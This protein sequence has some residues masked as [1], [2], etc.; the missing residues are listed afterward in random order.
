MILSFGWIVVQ[1]S[2]QVVACVGAITLAAGALY[3]GGRDIREKQGKESIFRTHSCLIE[4]LS[5]D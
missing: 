3:Y 5:Y 1:S 4:Y 2:T